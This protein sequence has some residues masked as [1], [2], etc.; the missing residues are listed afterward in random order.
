MTLQILSKNLQVQGFDK[1]RF[2]IA[3]TEI[4]R[5]DS[6]L[7]DMLQLARPIKMTRTMNAL[8]DIV[9]ECLDLLSDKAGSRGI[10]IHFG[11][12]PDD[13]KIPV[14]FSKMEEVFLNLFL[15]AMDA[16]PH[17]GEIQVDIRRVDSDSGPVMEVEIKD[18][19]T[20][21]SFEHLSH[22]FDPFFS[23]KAKGAGLGLANVKRIVEAHHG[24]IDVKSKVGFGA[25]FRIRLPLE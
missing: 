20:G 21:I 19:G 14:D 16:L 12:P 24:T 22:I 8:S 17:G 2:E 7:Q 10:W 15:N 18:S 23:T 4:K 1:K 9:T 11:G 5:L 3:L 6:F 13:G 25:S